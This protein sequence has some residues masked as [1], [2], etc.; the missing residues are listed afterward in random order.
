MP[1]G[2]TSFS[3]TPAS[4]PS[5]AGSRSVPARPSAWSWISTSRASVAR[6]SRP[7]RA[8][9]RRWI[10]TG[11]SWRRTSKPLWFASGGRPCLVL[12]ARFKVALP[13]GGRPLPA[14]P[15]FRRLGT[16]VLAALVAAP[17]PSATALPPDSELLA[18][19]R[20]VPEGDFDG[21]ALTLDAV[22][23]RL[24]EDPSPGHDLP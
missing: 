5:I 21:A 18:A 8:R 12:G 1:A 15:S 11:P 2:T 3:S 23:R 16:F 4:N 10:A 19:I 7:T 22:A 9:R 14:I 17:P 6:A 24:G 13:V 20:Q